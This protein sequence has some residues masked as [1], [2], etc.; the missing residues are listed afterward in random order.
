MKK[1]AKIAK[2]LAILEKNYPL[3]DECFLNYNQ[4]YQ[5]LFATI[6]SAQCTDVR[7]NQVTAVLFEKYAS[8][9]AFAQ[10]DYS[11]LCEDVQS[12]GFFRMKAKH[13]IES[14]NIL[15]TE[16]NGEVPS[17]IDALTALPGVGRKTANVVRGHIFQIP[18]IVVDTHVKRVSFRLGVTSQ[19]A[20]PEKAEQELMQVL[21]QKNWIAYNQQIILHGRAICKSQKPKCTAC[22]FVK[23]CENKVL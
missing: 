15:L 16:H 17:D 14:A 8:L 18:S 19:Q 6:L 2:I 12:T 13:I 9:Q 4:P 20:S 21:P 23:L 10:A 11:E 22:P 7:V 5:L 1:S 3:A